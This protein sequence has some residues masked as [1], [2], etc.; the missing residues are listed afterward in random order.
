[1]SRSKRGS[2]ADSY[3]NTHLFGADRR[4]YPNPAQ[5]RELAIERMIE[6]KL[7]EMAMNRYQWSGLDSEDIV[8]DERFLEMCLLYNGLAVV[9]FDHDYDK[10]MAVRGTANGYT[11]MLDNPTSFTV[12][13][14]GSISKPFT[15]TA[16]AQYKNKTISAYQEYMKGK[17]SDEE[18][19]KKAV[20]IWPNYL[21]T[22]DMDMISIYA[23]K[24][25]SVDRT[26]EINMKNAR[27]TKVLKAT[28]N[29]KLSVVNANR[30][31]DTGEEVVIVTGGM[32][33]LEFIDTIDLGITG[34]DYEKVHI[35]RTRL[36]NEAMSLLGIDG[37]NQDKK[38]RL[39]ANEVDANDEQITTMKY[40]N[41]NARQNACRQINE[42]F[43]TNISV[44]F[45]VNIE[46]KE[47][48]KELIKD[49]KTGGE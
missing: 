27:R 2:A 34:A 45:R 8:I 5:Q 23:N 16:P 38:E 19:R 47:T 3:Y 18:L 14:P 9:Y 20:A 37:A 24:I 4:F 49:E 33:D 17:K 10:L 15:D 22:S 30:S 11:N 32:E 31:I 28:P 41:L 46:N 48:E 44:D 6:K 29:T 42:V 43:G 7:V 35:V 26:I 21:R 12:V 13:G 1:M 39:T 25:A 40:V 36:W